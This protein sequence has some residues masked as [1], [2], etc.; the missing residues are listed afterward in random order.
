MLPRIRK[1]VESNAYSQGV[2]RHSQGEIRSMMIKD[3]AA[4]SHQIGKNWI[5][6]EGKDANLS[7]LFD[8]EFVIYNYKKLHLNLIFFMIE[9]I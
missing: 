4:I 3:L 9:Y 1:I 5:Y 2:G 6:G 8:H 7:Q